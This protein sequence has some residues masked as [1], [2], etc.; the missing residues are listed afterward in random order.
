M[1]DY[2]PMAMDTDELGPRVTIREV[3]SF[4]PPPRR[5][6]VSHMPMLTRHVPRSLIR[7]ESI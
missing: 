2:D 4:V 7:P 1:M 3:A 6:P 5:R